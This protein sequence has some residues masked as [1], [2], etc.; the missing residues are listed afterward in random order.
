MSLTGVIGSA[1]RRRNEALA[2]FGASSRYFDGTDDKINLAAGS[3]PV[4]GALTVACWVKPESK[5][6]NSPWFKFGT[7]NG[8]GLFANA[9]PTLSVIMFGAASWSPNSPS[10]W[11]DE[12]N[13]VVF[14]STGSGSL[15][16]YRDGNSLGNLSA[17]PVAATNQG[18]IGRNATGSEAGW[19]K[20]LIADV[21]TYNR[22]LS[23]S[24]VADLTN[25]VHVASGLVGWWLTDSDDVLDHSGNGNHATNDG[26]AFSSD[27]PLD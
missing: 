9:T 27:G 14:T 26:S 2:T 5:S 21:R 1:A 24:E 6:G 7:T 20:G 17:T 22:V 25:G 12:W 13:H 10:G 11:Y 23:A 15:G 3:S 19:F 4:S 8:Y 18:F 16:F